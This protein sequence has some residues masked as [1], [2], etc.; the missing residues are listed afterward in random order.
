MFDE[1]VNSDITLGFKLYMPTPEQ[2]SIGYVTNVEAYLRRPTEANTN[3]GIKLIFQN[4]RVYVNYYSIAGSELIFKEASYS[5]TD[6][7]AS[8]PIGR[9]AE[10]EIYMFGTSFMLAMDGKVIFCT[11]DVVYDFTAARTSRLWTHVSDSKIALA[12]IK[13]EQ[14]V[15]FRK[16]ITAIDDVVFDNNGV[17]DEAQRQAAI[18]AYG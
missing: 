5:N 3:Y 1:T 9:W 11:D 16:A 12:D 15:G 14:L 4:K 10:V 2:E 17:A 6:Y 18:T 13:H 8:T 7:F